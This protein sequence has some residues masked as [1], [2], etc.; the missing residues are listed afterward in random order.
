MKLWKNHPAS[1]YNFNPHSPINN[2]ETSPL[3][4]EQ[5]KAFRVLADHSRAVAF[6]ITDGALPGNEGRNYVL[7]RILRRAFYYSHKLNQKMN[8]LQKGAETLISLMKGVY[9]ELEREANLIHSLIEAEEKQF[10]DSLNFG[11]KIFI[12]KLKAQPEKKKTLDSF[13]VWDL[14]STYGFPFDLTRLMAKEKGYEINLQEVETLKAKERAKQLKDQ[15]PSKDSF[16][17]RDNLLNRET[18]PAI[19]DF[20]KE[21]VRKKAI[22][23]YSQ[24]ID[25]CPTEFTGYKNQED[26]GKILSLWPFRQI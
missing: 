8:L 21:E 23:Y 22:R 25:F 17:L 26:K 13:M 24:M 19:P 7:R 10:S 12:K 11:R 16:S 3:I 20:V 18:A 14:Y 9:P 6:L 5:D 4:S 15:I 1:S 2:K